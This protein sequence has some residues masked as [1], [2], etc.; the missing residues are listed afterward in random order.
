MPA[1]APPPI[2]TSP[3]YHIDRPSNFE[4]FP[5]RLLILTGWCFA[6][7]GPAVVSILLRCDNGHSLSTPVALARPEVK[8]ATPTAPSETIGFELRGILEKGQRTLSV[9]ARL[10]DGSEHLLFTRNTRVCDSLRPLWLRNARA[11]YDEFFESQ[12]SNQ[13]RYAPRPI[14]PERFPTHPV[15]ARLRDASPRFAIVTPSYNQAL[16][17]PETMASVLDQQPG[18]QVD[19]VLQDGGSTDG[20]VELIRAQADRLHAW[21][22]GP[23]GGQ[24][25]A[26]I[27]GFAKTTGG[28]DDLMAWLN[29]DD[30]Y[31]PGALRY[32]ANYF[33]THPEV[34]AV[35]GHRILV[36]EHSREISRWWLPS[37]DHALT[38][39][40]DPVPQETL[41]WRRRIWDKVG[42]LNPDY[43]YAM[44]W[45]LILRFQAAG[46]RIVRL[47]YFLGCFRTHALQKSYAEQESGAI[48]ETL[49]LRERGFG[50][51]FTPMEFSTHPRLLRHLRRSALTEWL[52]KRGIRI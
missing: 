39:I 49:K 7:T 15:K 41:F 2:A 18:A 19:Y 12:A 28:P 35:Y 38:L 52:W 23:D 3:R 10:E 1:A 47:P 36:D 32:V 13:A 34:D 16:W 9:F 26:I 14:S 20:S 22:S 11:H 25:R 29:S 44:D 30:F 46:A 8:A 37:H 4:R 43:R 40:N 27:N 5:T 48:H 31:L 42:G 50:R 6:E 33:A 24:S 17:L 51:P 21:E 45:E